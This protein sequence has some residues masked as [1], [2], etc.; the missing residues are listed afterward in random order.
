MCV[1]GRLV[2]TLS[3]DHPFVDVLY[4][5]KVVL[6]KPILCVMCTKNVLKI[7]TLQDIHSSSYIGHKKYRFYGET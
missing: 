7:N 6:G 5:R 4:V 2:R 3:R 1:G